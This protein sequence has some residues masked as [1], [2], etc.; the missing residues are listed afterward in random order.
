MA[1]MEFLDLLIAQAR[2]PQVGVDAALDAAL[3]Q[4]DR[5]LADLARDL[6]VEYYGPSIGV[7]GGRAVYRLVVRAHEWRIHER[8]WSL[9]IC[10]ALPHA[11]WRADWAIQS[12]ARRR[13][14]LIVH[15]LP[16]FFAGYAA[17]V[18]AAGKQATNAG[19]RL[20]DVARRFAA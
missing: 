11:H 19:R 20:Q 15:A 7:D 13:K 17:A 16:E 3:T 5:M 6:A 8:E 18:A 12:A 1:S 9:K 4:L 10:T 2:A 14:M